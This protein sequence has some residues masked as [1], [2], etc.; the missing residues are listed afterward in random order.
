[1]SLIIK[2]LRK[3][4]GEKVI[5]DDFT[6]T[7]ENSGIYALVGDSGKGKTTLLRMIAGLDKNY[8]G[9]ILTDQ[10][11]YVFQEYRL[12]PVLNAIDNITKIL[13]KQPTD[14][15]IQSAASLLATLG[16]SKEDMLLY[17]NALSGGMKQRV[18]L[19]RALLADKK[20]LLLDEPF[21]E[22]DSTLREQLRKILAEEAKKRLILLSA[23]SL[24]AL[25]DLERTII[26]IK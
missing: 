2:N 11:A 3:S 25:G 20:I 5:F 26:E 16:F 9:E 21:K 1:M 13:W 23:H 4:F 24:D 7:F 6:Y 22:L 14:E 19:C 15:Q 10:V 12:F 17:P 8:T 18:S